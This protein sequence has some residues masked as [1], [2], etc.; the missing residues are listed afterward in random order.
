MQTQDGAHGCGK[1]FIQAGLHWD[2]RTNVP[3]PFWG[4]GPQ[5]SE[6]MSVKKWNLTSKILVAT[7][8]GLLAGIL[9][10]GYI[11]PLRVIGDIFLRLVQMNIVLLVLGH[12]VEAVGNMNPR[13]LGKLGLKTFVIFVVTSLL[14][15]SWG[16]LWGV[17]FR[18]GSGVDT[19]LLSATAEIQAGTMSLTDT[20]L[21]FVP[22]NI[23]KSMAE[24]TVIHVIVF[25][26]LFGLAA[27]YVAAEQGDR[28]MLELTS[29][30]NKTIIK[31]ISFIM[32]IA[33]LSIGVIIATTV[34]RLGIQIIIP[35]AKYLGI[36]AAAT[37]A[38]WLL[39]QL[40]VCAY[41]KVNLF[42]LIR[43]MSGISLM[44]IT[45]VSSAVTLPTTLR[46]AQEKCGIGS[47]TAR[48][49]LPLGMSLNCDGAGMHMAITVITIAQMYGVTYDL[50]HLV[51][52][53][54]LCT[55]ASMANAVAPGASVVSLSIV[56][57]AMGL[58]VESIVL[59]ASV[60]YFVGMLRTVLNVG[61]DVFTAMLVAKSEGD[62]DYAVFNRSN[63][64]PTDK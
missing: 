42:K 25:G 39:Y 46:D 20:L 27:G 40:A 34:G 55:L 29:L 23:I 15:V 36:Y 10:G 11:Q 53:V 3:V 52:I 59:F 56:V 38:Y 24:G 4:T 12:V 48:L 45:T 47:K 58:P 50:Q 1:C 13:E 57:P 49:V 37:L 62:L 28:R 22:S 54:V 9:F 43:N 32:K 51:Y 5:E 60:D 44:A 31:V 8:L 19:T 2:R 18:P 14:G 41:C 33:P 16:A 26:I 64:S 30:F 21:S 7:A 63:R 35:L 6:R 61:S 17:V